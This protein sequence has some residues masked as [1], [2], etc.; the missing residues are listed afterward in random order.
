MKSTI[1]NL[2]L[3]MMLLFPLVSCRDQ[4]PPLATPSTLKS[5]ANV[6]G[7]G[8]RRSGFVP[9]DNP[10]FLSVEESSSFLEDEMIL[11]LEWEGESR[12]YPMRMLWFHHVVNDTIAGRP[13]LITF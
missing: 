8:V 7:S 2:F 4:A 5:T 12:A 10:V 9:L 1:T 6:D 3:L 11:A 13:F